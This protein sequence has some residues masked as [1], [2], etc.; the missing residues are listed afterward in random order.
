MLEEVLKKRIPDNLIEMS[1]MVR[2]ID[3]YRYEALIDKNAKEK[4]LTA[5]K[6]RFQMIKSPRNTAEDRKFYTE[7]HT[8]DEKEAADNAAD[9]FKYAGDK[10]NNIQSLIKAET[11]MLKRS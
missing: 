5:T 8:R 6:N 10:I 3:Q 11:E 7:F 2:D 9:I 4:N 1:N